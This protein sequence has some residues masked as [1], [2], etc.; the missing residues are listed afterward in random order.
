[1][2]AT[3]YGVIDSGFYSKPLET[4]DDEIDAGLRGILGES[5]GTTEEGKI[6]TESFAGQLKALLVDRDSAIW[7]LMQSVYASFDPNKNTGASQDAVASIS[8]SLRNAESYSIA[9]GTCVGDANTVLLA[10][11]VASASDTGSRFASLYDTTIA[12]ATGW[13]ASTAYP[14]LA[15]VTNNSQ[16][17]RCTAS[18]TSAGSIGPSGTSSSI[19]DG[20]ATWK[21][22][23]QGNGVVD[24]PFQ[25]ETVGAIGGLAGVISEIETPVSGWNA[26]SNRLDA[27]V[28]SEREK[29]SAFRQRRDQELASAGNTTVDAIRANILKVNEGSSDPNHEPP[30]SCT[31][32]Y[33][34]TDYTDSDGLPPHSVEILVQDGTTADIAQAI[35]E[36]VGAGTR[37]YGSR[38][39]T[40]EDS[41]GNSQTVY[42]TRPTEVQIWVTATGRYDAAQWPSGSDS[43]VAQNILSALLTYAEDFPIS[44]DVRVSPLLAAIMRGPAETDD[45]G[46][47]VVPADAASLPVV[48]LLEVDPLY[49]G[50]ATGPT[51]TAQISITRRQIAVFDS[52]R[53]TIT[54]SPESP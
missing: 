52:T 4:I 24:V 23:G 25:A 40:V 19:T 17:F 49:I 44:T 28:G 37:T 31:V 51:G 46:N 42:W 35:W 12:T 45:D 38:S 1:M 50:S 6:P 3:G 21:Y 10:G 26:V 8:G 29:D 41:E 14:A 48:G 30:T 47:A 39:D 2:A 32:F 34:D 13:Q 7:D 43:L 33:N 15:R 5:A 54:A 9:T 20:T 18:G 16:V 22:L 53:C 27:E 36:S 11:R